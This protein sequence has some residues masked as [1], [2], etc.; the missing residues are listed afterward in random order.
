MIDLA[1][2]I[3]Q[4]LLTQDSWVSGAT[5]CARFGIADDRDLRCW[6]ETPG[7]ISAFAISHTRK[8]YRH[9]RKASTLEWLAFKFTLMRHAISVI[10][11]VRGLAR[12]RHNVFL[13]TLPPTEKDS[14]Q[15]VMTL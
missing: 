13:P 6:G 15:T 11:R 1:P 10:R 5:L 3:E 12:V 7:L 14:G 9:V 2:Q 8:G 4:W